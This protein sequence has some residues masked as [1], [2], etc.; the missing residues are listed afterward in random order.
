MWKLLTTISGFYISRQRK[1]LNMVFFITPA[2]GDPDS[3]IN[4]FD[5][6][7]PKEEMRSRKYFTLYS[8][9]E[10]AKN[11]VSISAIKNLQATKIVEKIV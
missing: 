10:R 2:S 11:R 5:D 6:T 7:D 3:I 1:P 9:L 8:E 4:K